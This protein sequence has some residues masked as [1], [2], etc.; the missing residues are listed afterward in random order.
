MARS[1]QGGKGCLV[2]AVR[3]KTE[4]LAVLLLLA[5]SSELAGLFLLT[6]VCG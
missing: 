5:I 3:C 2:T 4:R 1:H 6:G